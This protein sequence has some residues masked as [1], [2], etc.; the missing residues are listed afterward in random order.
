MLAS[1]LVKLPVCLCDYCVSLPALFPLVLFLLSVA[2]SILTLALPFS[3]SSVPVVPC[4]RE[5][6]AGNKGPFLLF[7][8]SGYV[9]IPRGGRER[10]RVNGLAGRGWV[11]GWMDGVESP[12]PPTTQDWSDHSR[13]PRS[14]CNGRVTT[15]CGMTFYSPPSFGKEPFAF[16]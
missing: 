5:V 1:P 6:S 16:F 11:G 12:Q 9:G 10:E 14:L 3:R 15:L 13:V 2:L 4:Y 8:I 7:W